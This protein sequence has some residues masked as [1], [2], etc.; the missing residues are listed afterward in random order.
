[1]PRTLGAKDKKKRKRRRLLNIALGVGGAAALGGL[2]YLAYKRRMPTI[3]KASQPI[4]PTYI[5]NTPSVSRSPIPRTTQVSTSPPPARVQTPKEPKLI[6]ARAEIQVTPTVATQPAPKPVK[7]LQPAKEDLSK[8]LPTGKPKLIPSKTEIQSNIPIPQAAP[9][10]QTIKGLLPPA[11]QRTIDLLPNGKP[12]LIP[13]RA[14]IQPNSLISKTQSVSETKI[15]KALPPARSPQLSQVVP[16]NKPKLAPSRQEIPADTNIPNP[17]QA[18]SSST[19][20]AAGKAGRKAARVMSEVEKAAKKAAAEAKKAAKKAKQELEKI[21]WDATT[22]KAAR[23]AG[24]AAAKVVN[25]E[26]TKQGVKAVQKGRKGIKIVAK[27]AKKT[28]KGRQK[29]IINAMKKGAGETVKRIPGAAKSA[30]ENLPAAGKAAGKL[31]KAAQEANDAIQTAKDATPK[32]G[33]RFFL[34]LT[35][36][37]VATMG[38]QAAASTAQQAQRQ[39]HIVDNYFRLLS[40]TKAERRAEAAALRASRIAQRAKGHHPVLQPH[41]NVK[42]VEEDLINLDRNIQAI[43]AAGAKQSTRRDIILAP[44]EYVEDYV[45]KPENLPKL[46]KLFK[47]LGLPTVDN[48]VKRAIDSYA[49]D[50]SP[51]A[52]LRFTQA[53]LNIGRATGL[54][55]NK[56][57]LAE[58]I[59]SDE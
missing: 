31:A 45:S 48:A 50:F 25:Q 9:E 27:V 57:E 44:K 49:K 47:K 19:K 51:N 24:K 56:K 11:K 55:S 37:R 2:G 20:T 22:K 36:A 1:M 26:A 5:N 21:D 8:L 16:P 53:L 14:E 29:L 6:P 59:E 7:V 34:T 41:Y 39:Y 28:K 54:F 52:R 38:K 33:R 17:T 30:V 12:K 15:V 18:A 13:S 35:G 4:Q 40:K 3:G 10:T 46:V 23:G 43:E 58:F 32:V 42:A